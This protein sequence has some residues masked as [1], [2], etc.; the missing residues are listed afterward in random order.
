MTTQERRFTSC[1]DEDCEAFQQ[2]DTRHFH[3]RRMARVLGLDD[4]SGAGTDEAE[5][6]LG[7]HERQCRCDGVGSDRTG[8]ALTERGAMRGV[9]RENS[10]RR[11]P[12]DLRNAAR[13]SDRRPVLEGDGRGLDA[14]VLRVAVVGR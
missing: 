6:G 5:G 14:L 11:V 2:G 12:N 10:L 3:G 1:R 7:A 9:H 8:D 4:A 13:A